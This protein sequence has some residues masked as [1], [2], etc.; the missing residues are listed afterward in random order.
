[1]TDLHAL[2]YFHLSE[3]CAMMVLMAEEFLSRAPL[4]TKQTRLQKV[5]WS[6]KLKWNFAQ[7]DWFLWLRPEC[8]QFILNYFYISEMQI[9]PN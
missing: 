1:M 2:K 4:Y 8:E 3:K 6:F 5:S 9:S 7:F